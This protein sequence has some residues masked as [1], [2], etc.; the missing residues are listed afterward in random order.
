MMPRD[1][2]LMRTLMLRFE[3]GDDSIPPGVSPMD[4]AYNVE[5]LRLAGLLDAVVTWAPSPGKRRPVKFIVN[6][7]TPAGHDFIAAVKNEQIW[8]KITEDLRAKSIPL[9]IDLVVDLAKKHL[10]AEAGL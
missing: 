9:T 2:E 4:A 10:R 7:I 1:V 3:Q 6:D 5:Q 8:A